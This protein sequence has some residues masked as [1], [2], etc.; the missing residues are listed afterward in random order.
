MSAEAPIRIQHLYISPAHNFFGHNGL[1][2]GE[3]VMVAQDEVMC[4]AGRGI[5]GDRFLDFKR[6]YKGQ[7]TFFNGEIHAELCTRFRATETPPSVYRRNVIILGV[8]LNSLIGCEFEVQGIR[9]LGM[10]ECTPC[11]WMDAA[12]QP[13]TEEALRNRGGLRA[14][15]LTTGTLKVDVGV[16]EQ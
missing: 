9:F 10:A 11:H 7:I 8:D 5:E 13:G 4:L 15:I 6:N 3:H 12:F 14:K 16:T 2:P 1:P